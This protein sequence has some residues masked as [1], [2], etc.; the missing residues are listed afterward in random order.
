M[1]TLILL[2]V[3]AAA[4]LWPATAEKAPPSLP[5]LPSEPVSSRPTYQT[6]IAALATI[7]RRLSS[8]A[9]LTDAEKDAINL[10]TLALVSGSED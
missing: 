1:M 3:A 5:S 7:R 8:T 4:L 10:L 6:A 2:A 9:S